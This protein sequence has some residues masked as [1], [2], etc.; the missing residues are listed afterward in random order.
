MPG[1]QMLLVRCAG[2]NAPTGKPRSSQSQH[3]GL[4][5]SQDP[6]RYNAGQFDVHR[7]ATIEFGNF[8]VCNV[9]FAG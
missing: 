9:M 7:I 6:P 1:S 5:G 2:I 8:N 3:F 4:F